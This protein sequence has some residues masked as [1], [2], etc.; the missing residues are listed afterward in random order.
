MAIGAPMAGPYF[1]PDIR[2]PIGRPRSRSAKFSR[3]YRMLAGMTIA[4]P[5][6]STMRKAIRPCSELTNAVAAEA[7][8]HRNMASRIRPLE[9]ETVHRP[10]QRE[11]AARYKPRK[12]RIARSRRCCGERKTHP[13]SR[14][15][16]RQVDA[17]GVGNDDAQGEER[18]HQPSRVAARVNR[19]M[20]RCALVQLVEQATINPLVDGAHPVRCRARP[21]PQKC[22]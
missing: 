15:R 14:E 13:D 7:A 20:E 18:N 11:F 17:V 10:I 3:I 5:M 8:L 2:M 16:S 4:S 19:V 21:S 12:R 9:T 1:V 22:R 6:P